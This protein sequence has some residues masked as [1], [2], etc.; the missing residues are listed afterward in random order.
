[1]SAVGRHEVHEVLAF[2]EDP[3]PSAQ[4]RVAST[5]AEVMPLIEVFLV[6]NQ[7]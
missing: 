4:F 7:A 3:Q 2:L 6:V 1:M 5:A